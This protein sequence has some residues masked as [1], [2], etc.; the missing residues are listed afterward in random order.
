MTSMGLEK[1]TCMSEIDLNL[2]PLTE[3]PRRRPR[4]IKPK[5]D[6]RPILWVYDPGQMTGYAKFRLGEFAA[7]LEEC[8]EFTT[9]TLLPAQ[10]KPKDL[11]VYEKIIVRMHGFNP[12]GLEV[13]GAIKVLCQIHK[14]PC[15]PRSH[16]ELTGIRKWRTYP[17][18]NVL[19]DHAKDAIHHGVL[20]L[21]QNFGRDLVL[22]GL[23]I[24]ASA[25][26]PV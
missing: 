18:K 9:S 14:V 10:I 26:Y 2:R 19:S 23:D 8:G 4:I 17:L 11:V 5:V 15:Y 12:V 16:Q 20:Y 3:E 24:A 13:V 1:I 21:K 25:R 22:T 7:E 6:T